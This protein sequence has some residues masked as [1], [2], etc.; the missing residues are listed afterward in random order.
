[1][2]IY[3]Q[4]T[5]SNSHGGRVIDVDPLSEQITSVR[6]VKECA[7]YYRPIEKI[8]IQS[9]QTMAINLHPDFEILCK[10]QLKR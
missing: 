4:F 3:I 2:R 7:H 1:M 5:D 8:S 6:K 10:S 9:Q